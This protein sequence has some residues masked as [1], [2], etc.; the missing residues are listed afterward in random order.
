[1]VELSKKTLGYIMREKDK[2]KQVKIE[3]AKKTVKF[4][5]KIRDNKECKKLQECC[6]NLKSSKPKKKKQITK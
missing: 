1:M 2:R 5:N 3:A 4:K 6:G